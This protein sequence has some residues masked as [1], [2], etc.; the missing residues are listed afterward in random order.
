MMSGQG[1]KELQK[2]HNYREITLFQYSY[3]YTLM[4]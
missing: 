1:V 4:S 2:E 3:K